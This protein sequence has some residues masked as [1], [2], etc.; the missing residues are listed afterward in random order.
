MVGK[1]E[2]RRTRTAC[3]RLGDHSFLTKLA[4]N[5]G[6]NP[7]FRGRFYLKKPLFETVLLTLITMDGS[8][9]YAPGRNEP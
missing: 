9:A 6:S 7:L 4:S 2:C 1:L 5:S 8:I 3:V